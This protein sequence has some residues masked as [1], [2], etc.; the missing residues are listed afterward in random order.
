MQRVAR[1]CKPALLPTIAKILTHAGPSSAVSVRC[2]PHPCPRRPWSIPARSNDKRA[3]RKLPQ[4]LPNTARASCLPVL[5]SIPAELGPSKPPSRT[6]NWRRVPCFSPYSNFHSFHA[7]EGHQVHVEL[8]RDT[9]GGWREAHTRA[10]APE[11]PSE[12]PPKWP[13]CEPTVRPPRAPPGAANNAWHHQ[14]P[15]P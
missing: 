4:T 10:G 11:I 2:W 7:P 3:W 13:V 6:H 5:S 12:I 8:P 14:E 1:T 9:S 15:H